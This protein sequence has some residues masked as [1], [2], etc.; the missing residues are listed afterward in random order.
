LR[1]D[2]VLRPNTTSLFAPLVPGVTNAADYTGLSIYGIWGSLGT[3][4]GAE[5]AGLP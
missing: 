5:T 3:I 4:R 1:V 2:P